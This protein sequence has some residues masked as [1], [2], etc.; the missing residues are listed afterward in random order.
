MIHQASIE[1]AA[2]PA[3]RIARALEEAEPSPLAVGLFDRGGGR[4]QV[5]AHYDLPPARNDLAAL[6][7]AAAGDDD[8]GPLS[9]EALA[10]EDWVTVSQ[11]KRGPVQAG[12]FFVHGSHDRARAPRH[13]FVIEI[14]A[15]QAFG[16]AHH[17]T[18][19]GCLLALDD[20]L[21]RRRF[22][23]IVDI[24]TG[25]GVLA[26]A[27]AN[28]LKRQVLASDSD[29]VAAA[30]AGANAR[31]NCAGPQ[32][33]V[34]QA[35]GFAHPRLWTVKADLILA[36]LLERAHFD[37]APAYAKHVVPGGA[38]VLSGLTE[39][40]ARSIEARTRAYGFV[41]E[42]R[43]ILDGWSTLVITRRSLRPRRD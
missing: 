3:E 13:R 35:I 23:S 43:I 20:L 10:P 14:D 32:V 5:F 39:T 30:I 42:K 38:A 37:L 21:K 22:R 41:L 34:V 33:R 40:Q 11:G 2:Q 27:A 36:N 18:T 26:I 12:R 28:A 1:A 25:T 9:I 7:E 6:I 16:T 29:A 8:L 19:R 31:D 15:G 24:G 4:F 17:A